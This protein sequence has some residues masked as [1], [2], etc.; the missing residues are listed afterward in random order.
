[1]APEDFAGVEIRLSEAEKE[2]V[3]LAKE[4]KMRLHLVAVT[5]VEYAPLKSVRVYMLRQKTGCIW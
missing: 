4:N 1:V 3:R 5:L 2:A